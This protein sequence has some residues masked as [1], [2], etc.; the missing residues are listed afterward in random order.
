MNLR[1]LKATTYRQLRDI[2]ACDGRPLVV[3]DHPNCHPGGGAADGDEAVTTAGQDHSTY[4]HRQQV[5]VTGCWRSTLH[6]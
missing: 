5:K 4:S 1:T 3:I 6:Y 2:D